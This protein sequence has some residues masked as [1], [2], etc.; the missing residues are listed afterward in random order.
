MDLTKGK[1]IVNYFDDDDVGAD[2][3][4][5]MQEIDSKEAYDQISNTLIRHGNMDK[6]NAW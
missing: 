6:T 2:E 4:A 5:I 3:Y 1:K